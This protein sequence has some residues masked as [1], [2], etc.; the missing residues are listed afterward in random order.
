M[1]G[2]VRD[3]TSVDSLTDGEGRECVFELV[4]GD[5]HP[6]ISLHNYFI[7]RSRGGLRSRVRSRRRDV[8]SGRSP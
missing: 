2:F 4:N 5:K 6:Y 8:R 7:L 1:G 3:K